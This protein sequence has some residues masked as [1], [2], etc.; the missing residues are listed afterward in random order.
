MYIGNRVTTMRNKNRRLLSE[1]KKDLDL[2][3][4]KAL[5]GAPL[6]PSELTELLAVNQSDLVRDHGCD[7]Y[8]A[9]QVV[10]HI[11]FEQ[12]RMRSQNLYTRDSEMADLYPEKPYTRTSPINE[13]P[14]SSLRKIASDARRVRHQ[15]GGVAELP[16]WCEHKIAKSQAMLQTVSRYLALRSNEK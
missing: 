12:S 1:A 14:T 8:M 6:R 13:S 2:A 15:V 7:L 16:A 3:V 11:K 10:N 9:E 5:C 4:V